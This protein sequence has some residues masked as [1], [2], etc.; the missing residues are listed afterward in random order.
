MISV[1]NDG[2]KNY[3][4]KEASRQIYALTSGMSLK[5]RRAELEKDGIYNLLP[6]MCEATKVPCDPA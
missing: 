2:G 4:Q 1:L 5:I 6:Y 3:P